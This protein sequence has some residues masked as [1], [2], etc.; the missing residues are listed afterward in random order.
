MELVGNVPIIYSANPD[1]GV[2][3]GMIGSMIELNRTKFARVVCKDG[4]FTD[5]LDSDGVSLH[6][7]GV[8]IDRIEINIVAGQPARAILHVPIIEMDVVISNPKVEEHTV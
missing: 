6:Q 1:E 5:V 4:V 7:R 3:A 8:I 2:D